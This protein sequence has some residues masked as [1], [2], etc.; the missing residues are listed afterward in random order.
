[1]KIIAGLAIIAI[2]VFVPALAH[3]KSKSLVGVSSDGSV[4][5]FSDGSQYQV[6]PSY[7]SA[8]SHW[9][10]GDQIEIFD[11]HGWV[12]VPIINPFTGL[13]VHASRI[14]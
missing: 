7:S 1:M 8:I 12:D 3:A 10:G 9:S 14:Q 11:H 13:P 4:L 5:T 2:C 6:D